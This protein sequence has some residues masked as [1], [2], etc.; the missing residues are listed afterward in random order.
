MKRAFD[1]VLAV[2]RTEYLATVRTRAF[3]IALFLMPVLSLGALSLPFLFERQLE[4]A[5][6]RCVVFDDSDVLF[7]R[8]QERATRDAASSP[9]EAAGVPRAAGLSLERIDNPQGRSRD[10]LLFEQSERVRRGEIFA[11]VEVPDYRAHGGLRGAN[12][13]P[14]PPIRYYSE[15]PTYGALQAWFKHALQDEVFWLQLGANGIPVGQVRPTPPALQVEEQAL[16][17]RQ[18]ETIIKPRAPDPARD[19]GLPIGAVLLMFS[20]VMLGVGPLMQSALEEKMQRIAEVLVSSV[21]PFQL[22]LGKLLGASAVSYTLLALYG[23]GALV[24]GQQLGL[25]WL[26][27]ASLWLKL[28]GF[29][30]IALLMYGSVFLAVGSACNDL[31]E[32]QALMMP[33]MIVITSP[34]LLLQLVLVEPN[35]VA[36]TLASFFPPFTPV[37]MLLRA[38][39]P[40]GAPVWHVLVGGICSLAFAIGCLWAASRVFRVGMLV[41][42][43]TPSYRTL[44]GWIRRG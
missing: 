19:L 12:P 6:K 29:Q 10:E 42:G 9:D 15:T 40:P 22:L 16:L 23:A 11:I 17:E 27:A 35:S 32:S 21:P 44:L 2:A 25:D 43:G 34:L 14:Y 26:L 20:S 38:T 13:A 30:A 4:R 33:V 8:L 37:L 41:Q 31:K 5:P 7:E 24:L 18:G 39:L 28:L 36:S 1:K 3:I